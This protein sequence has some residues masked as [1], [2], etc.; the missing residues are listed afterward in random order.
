[1]KVRTMLK[2]YLMPIGAFAGYLYYSY[3]GCATGTCMLSSNGYFMTFYGALLG[4]TIGGIISPG[5]KKEE[6]LGH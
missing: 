4:Y 2:Y 1:M 6:P 5:K 3:V